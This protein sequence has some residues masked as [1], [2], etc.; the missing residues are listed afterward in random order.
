MSVS[1]VPP[2][3]ESQHAAPDEVRAVVTRFLSR[4]VDD[5]QSLVGVR[6]LTGGLLDSLAAVEL[7]G[8]L[9]RTFGLV[10]LDEDLDID[11]FDSL[12]AITAFV[13]RKLDR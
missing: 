13:G 5:P 12:D 9:E 7:I 8:H 3:S 1:A 2:V 6:L 11:N 10:M 4:Y